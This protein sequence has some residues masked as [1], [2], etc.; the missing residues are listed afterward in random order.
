MSTRRAGLT[1]AAALLVAACSGGFGST[2]EGS[3]TGGTDNGAGSNGSTKTTP[4]V[5]QG[6]VTSPTTGTSSMMAFTDDT[7]HSVWMATDGRVWSGQMP[8][9]AIEFDD[10]M[11]GHIYPG[12][13][14]P[15]GTNHGTWSMH[16]SFSHGIWSGHLSGAGEHGT[17]TMS[18]HPARDLPASLATLAGTYT[19]TTS[20]G[21]TMTMSVTQ[22]GQLTASDTRGCLINGTVSVPDPAHNHYRIAATV[23][24]CGVLD[25][26]YEGHGTLVDASAM[27]GWMSEMGCFQY[28]QDGMMAGGM[29]HGGMDGWWPVGGTNTVPSGT[30]NLFMFAIESGRTAIMDALAR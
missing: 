11:V 15:D 30:G 3:V 13:H 5:W 9:S 18:M 1:V 23:T 8:V 4:G 24:S 12:A 26:N 14:F 27:Q 22:A 21:Y 20:I 10:S 2:S 16:A 28:G 7:G 25:G 29:G 6:T 19:R 17:F